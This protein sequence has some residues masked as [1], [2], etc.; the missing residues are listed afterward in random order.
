MN[1]IIQIALTILSFNFW[2]AAQVSTPL[3]TI[4]EGSPNNHAGLGVEFR[5]TSLDDGKLYFKGSDNGL[6]LSLWSTDGTPAGTSKLLEDPSEWGSNWDDYQFLDNGIL[7]NNDD[8]WGLFTAGATS[9]INIEGL[10]DEDISQ[11]IKT[12]DD[13]YYITMDIDDNMVVYLANEDFT[14][15]NELGIMHEKVNFLTLSAG[16]HGAIMFSTNSFV[17]DMPTIYVTETNTIMSAEAY[18]SSIG[19]EISELNYGYMYDK[20]F[21][22]SYAD[23]DNFS[24]HRIIDMSNGTAANFEFI[25]EPKQF[26]E[27]DNKLFI[28]TE[29]EIVRVNLSD[30]SY[31]FL[32]NSVY[33]FSNNHVSGNK[34][35]FVADPSDGSE[36]ISSFNMDSEEIT[37]YPSADIGSFF[38]DTRILEFDNE[39]YYIKKDEHYLLQKIDQETM[40]PITVDTLGVYTGA[41]VVFGL[42]QVNDKLVYSRRIGNL[43]HEL[44]VYDP[45]GTSNLNETV[46][47]E[48]SIYPTLAIDHIQ[49]NMESIEAQN[50]N[51]IEI[52]HAHGAYIGNATIENDH[53]INVQ[54]LPAGKYVGVINIDN[55]RYICKWI[56]I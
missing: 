21:I 4:T 10:P 56:K 48:L 38:Y 37:A 34:I 20:Y 23:A 47:E 16:S 24:R 19:I 28:I 22:V 50:D 9:L 41:T 51:K 12:T 5:G 13:N 25:R 49:I 15:V 11:I 18:M 52:Y 44:F 39:V 35:Y 27:H 46:T 29:R 26:V 45:D 3:V 36:H 53:T 31:S 17:E 40:N 33:V 8:Q 7:I 6:R 14:E 1:R 2:L 30:L 54:N 42:E 43:Q 32:Y 55:K